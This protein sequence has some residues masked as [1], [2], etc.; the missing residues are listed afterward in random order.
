MSNGQDPSYK[1]YSQLKIN[2]SEHIYSVGLNDPF[3]YGV[4]YLISF[5]IVMVA[6]PLYQAYLTGLTG[7]SV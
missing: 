3:N 7:L 4:V 2:I 5:D 1:V 6:I